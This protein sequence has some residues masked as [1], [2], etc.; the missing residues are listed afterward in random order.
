[1]TLIRQIVLHKHA[2]TNGTDNGSFAVIGAAFGSAQ[3][4]VE[5]S[6]SSHWFDIISSETE[7]Q[8]EPGRGKGAISMFSLSTCST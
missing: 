6:E 7:G 2:N 5:T 1:M 3:G 4:S 8:T